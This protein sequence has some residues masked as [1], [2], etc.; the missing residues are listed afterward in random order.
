MLRTIPTCP[1]SRFSAALTV[2][3]LGLCSVALSACERKPEPGAAEK[4]VAAPASHDL[5]TPSLPPPS[6]GR[7]ELLQAIAIARS[8]YG[9]GQADAGA[10]LAGRRFTIRQ[11]FGCAA[12]AA[13]GVKA[14]A[15]TAG[16]VWGRDRKSI[17]IR[18]TPADWTVA[19]VIAGGGERLGG[20]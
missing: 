19:P 4:P 2:A 13:S 16:W 17:D 7:A 8:A 18:L 3:I 10:S 9:S 20:R 5:A 14:E 1:R 12:E 15:G 11:A 6:V